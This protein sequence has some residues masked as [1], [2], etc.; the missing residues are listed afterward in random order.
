MRTADPAQTL[1]IARFWR[2]G[3]PV[4]LSGADSEDPSEE[5]VQTRLAREKR[6]EPSVVSLKFVHFVR[7]RARLRQGAAAD[8]TGGA[9]AHRGLV[10]QESRN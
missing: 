1:P 8:F 9:G 2:L 7:S 5:C 10:E 3:H 4:V 6:P